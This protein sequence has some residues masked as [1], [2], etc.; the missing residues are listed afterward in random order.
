[1]LAIIIIIK[2]FNLKRP[3]GSVD[4]IMVSGWDFLTGTLPVLQCR[5]Y[6]DFPR[7]CR[8]QITGDIFQCR[9]KEHF[10]IVQ[11]SSGLRVYPVCAFS[12]YQLCDL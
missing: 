6:A 1:M 11:A 10:N 8:I 2:V 4:V 7:E 12:T 3:L 9:F 5:T